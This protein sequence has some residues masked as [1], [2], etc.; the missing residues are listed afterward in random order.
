[1]RP[2]L[3]VV[4]CL[5]TESLAL[6]LSQEGQR[7]DVVTRCLAEVLS[8]ALSTPDAQLDQECRDIIKAGVNHASLSKKSSDGLVTQE[9][10]SKGHTEEPAAKAADVKDI[11]A[12]LK[13]VEE[14]RANLEDEHNQQSWSLGDRTSEN[15]DGGERVKRSSWRLGRYRQRKS[16]RGEEEDFERSQESWGGTEKRSEDEEVAEESEEK[17]KRSWRPGRYH[18][19]RHK[20]DDGEEEEPEEERSQESWDVNKRYEDE[21]ERDKRIWKPTHRYHHKSRL[22]KRSDDPLEGEVDEDRSQESWSVDKKNWRPGR[23]HQRRHKRDEE[24]LENAREEPDEER[25]QEYW[26]VDTGVEKRN[27]RPGRIHQRRHK[28]DEEPSEG[29]REEPDEERS[30]EYW[31]VDTGVEKRNWRPGRF[32]QRRHK[33]DEEPSEGNMEEPEEERSQEYWDFDTGVEKRNWRPG[34]FHQRR[35]R[36]DEEPSEGNREEPDEERSQE[37]WDF[38]TGMEKRNWRP[39]RFHQRRQRRDEELPEEAREEPEG[40]RSQE[41]WGYEKRQETEEGEIEKRIWKPTHRYHHKQ[42]LNKRAGGPSEEEQRGTSD[43]YTE[44]EKDRDEALRYLAEKRNPWISR[45]YYHPAWYK[46]DSEEPAAASNKM[47]QLAQLLSYRINQLAHHSA[48]EEAK[49]TRALTPPEENELENLA[50]MDTELR[51]IAAKL[52]D[53]PA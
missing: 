15:G 40:G 44:D 21:E 5:L 31:D 27:W 20:R 34:R 37:Y 14:E 50:A 22:H 17:E 39:G 24:P 51:K 45:G 18:Q 52:H 10:A 25:S 30:Q 46:R 23:Y 1:M 12:L 43:E 11:E 32:H 33:R 4:T 6:P 35:Q 13:S 28:R 53:K 42:R 2:I 36:R 3:V 47:D 48:Q 9:E 29:N 41:D 19:R 26:D 7:E 16:K 8:K 38:D 49:T